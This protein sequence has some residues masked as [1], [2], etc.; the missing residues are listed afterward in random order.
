MCFIVLE[1][2]QTRPSKKS[3]VL[4]VPRRP[5]PRFAALE[6]DRRPISDQEGQGPPP[7]LDSAKNNRPRLARSRGGVRKE[8]GRKESRQSAIVDYRSDIVYRH[9]KLSRLMAWIVGRKGGRRGGGIVESTGF[10]RRGR[11]GK[12][13]GAFPGSRKLV[14]TRLCRCLMRFTLSSRAQMLWQRFTKSRVEICTGLNAVRTRSRFCVI[15]RHGSA[16]HTYLSVSISSPRVNPRP[17]LS[18]RSSLFLFF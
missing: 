16:D 17:R 12:M 10:E 3:H 9:W 13:T 7:P 11:G 15:H 2:A 5:F 18:Q 4:C 6:I 1:T 14:L 8:R